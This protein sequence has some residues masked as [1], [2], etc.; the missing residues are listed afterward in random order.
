M[1]QQDIGSRD[2]G[3]IFHVCVWLRWTEYLSKT[4]NVLFRSLVS[5]ALA[6]HGSESMEVHT[7]HQDTQRGR[8]CYRQLSPFLFIPS[9]PQP[10]DR[11]ALSP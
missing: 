6:R 4:A 7:C 2:H 8:R 3:W 11:M 1:G 10:A 9:E 5:D